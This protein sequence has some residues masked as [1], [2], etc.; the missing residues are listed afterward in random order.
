MLSSS[1]YFE[2]ISNCRSIC[3]TS[4]LSHHLCRA[5]SLDRAHAPYRRKGIV[6][7]CITDDVHSSD[8][9]ALFWITS[10]VKRAVRLVT[11]GEWLCS[12]AHPSIMSFFFQGCIALFS[13]HQYVLLSFILLITCGYPWWNSFLPPHEFVKNS[14]LIEIRKKLNLYIN[15]NAV[16]IYDSYNE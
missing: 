4:L 5:F 11:H 2:F 6:A 3:R 15:N 14:I 8:D 13:H 16:I 10:T 12:M 7:F 1:R 9:F